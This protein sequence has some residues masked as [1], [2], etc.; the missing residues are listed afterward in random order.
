MFAFSQVEPR[1]QGRVTPNIPLS[2]YLGA[3][4]DQG[5]HDAMG[6]SLYRI[7]EQWQMENNVSLWGA[8]DQQ[9]GRMLDPNEA[10]D[11]YG[12]RRLRFTEPV[13][14]GVAELLKNRHD[15]NETRNFILS[16]GGAGV[17]RFAASFGVGMLA[18][19]S[20]PVDFTT[21]F[22]PI[23]GSEALATKLA[24]M[25]LSPVRQGLARGLI[26]EER[27]RAIVP[28]PRVVAAIIEGTVGQ[29]IAEVPL[30][31]SNR[32]DQ[33]PYTVMDSL[34]NIALGGA[35]A[36]TLRL[37]LSGA[38]RLVGRLMP[39]TKKALAQK[40][41]ADFLLGDD[42]KVH[43]LVNLD[44]NVIR[45]KVLFDVTAA[46]VEARKAVEGAGPLLKDWRAGEIRHWAEAQ[47]DVEGHLGKVDQPNLFSVAEDWIPIWKQ[48]GKGVEMVSKLFERAKADPSIE[49]LEG[50]AAAFNLKFDPLERKPPSQYYLAKP[51]ERA[52]LQKIA[53]VA[54]ED[55]KV[56]GQVANVK[57]REQAAAMSARNEAQI[58]KLVRE[59]KDR[60]IKAYVEDLRKKFDPEQET[61]KKINQEVMEQQKLGKVLSTEQVEKYKQSD[62]ITEQD[63]AV[64]EKD[65][66]NLK[67]SL[68]IKDDDADL[69]EFAD[70]LEKKME[71][72]GTTGAI[73][74][75]V[76][77]LEGLKIK[78]GGEGK[79]VRYSGV[80]PE[81]W[82]A[83]ID[84]VIAG[85][86]AGERLY[87]AVDAALAEL[88]PAS[89]TS[90][91]SW[92]RDAMIEQGKDP[93]RML[94]DADL[95]NASV[96]EAIKL[97]PTLT[98]K[99]KERV[100][101]TGS[102]RE[103]PLITKSQAEE[104][105][106][107]LYDR[108]AEFRPAAMMSPT[109]LR[110]DAGPMIKAANKIDEFVSVGTFHGSPEAWVHL[111]IDTKWWQYGGKTEDD[112]INGFITKT[113]RF[114]TRDEAA[115]L[116][117]QDESSWMDLLR[118][119][120]S[121]RTSQADRRR[122]L[123]E[124]AAL[125][126][127]SKSKDG[128]DYWHQA[129]IIDAFAEN[130]PVSK[131]A[132]KEYELDVPGHYVEAGDLLVPAGKELSTVMEDQLL[133]DN[134]RGCIIK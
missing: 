85:V 52:R 115:G 59:E 28:A 123:Q 67:K 131:L 22:V 20:N 34:R 69:R 6:G 12:T 42:V 73:E 125:K 32:M 117:G 62:R 75:I 50:L 102:M 90:L 54:D 66:E 2:R 11:R 124:E 48:Q 3:A 5:V 43:E 56:T 83:L 30:Y 89:K 100:L 7:S 60:R 127:L 58:Q 130:K 92:L 79:D 110:K 109:E 87:K 133:L 57:R 96:I 122:W 65:V 95:G 93:A 10:N 126:A 4:W 23:V 91:P 33:T 119:A 81:T 86:R 36:G 118:K 53:G 113:Q 9:A 55:L 70:V 114:V 134:L 40:G 74:H 26:T 61:R 44:E 37:A 72:G 8:L 116:S 21:M 128:F 97:D 99:Q 19:L 17:G 82:N 103:L 16:S 98:D 41:L 84:L 76:K 15:E 71:K 68:D 49:N 29:V 77:S 129:T 24:T 111:P 35:F 78:T 80:P 14:E 94:N 47:L 112:V 88:Q 108:V 1:D 13:Y 121:E 38:G 120:I 51:A 25:G 39:D 27:L 101:K 132:V 64:L 63:V 18:S 31:I 105:R 46:R 45:E 104:A 107:A 106:A